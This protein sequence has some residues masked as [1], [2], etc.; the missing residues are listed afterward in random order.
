MKTF[1][2]FDKRT[3]IDFGIIALIDL[4]AL[5]ISIGN[6]QN[7]K[8]EHTCSLQTYNNPNRYKIYKD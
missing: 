5:S 3:L 4:K 1:E 7:R 2:Y 8:D 6:F